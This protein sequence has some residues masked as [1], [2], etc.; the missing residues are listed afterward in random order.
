M[1]WGVCH[2]RES[3]TREQS[4]VQEVSFTSFLRRCRGKQRFCAQGRNPSP[5]LAQRHRGI[6]G[7]NGNASRD[8]GRVRAWSARPL[9]YSP[10]RFQQT[11]GSYQR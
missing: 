2:S 11:R 8:R 5:R 10:R 3:V 1:V 7:T 6:T 9:R 4:G